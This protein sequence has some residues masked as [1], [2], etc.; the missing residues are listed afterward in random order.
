MKVSGG[1]TDDGVIVGNTFDKYSSKNPIVRWIM[2]GFH[3][4]LNELV[5]AAGPTSIHE[6][7]CGEGYWV[8]RW[9]RQGLDARGSDFSPT[10]V[11][12]ANE[13]AAEQD[14]PS[15]LFNVRSI[16]ELRPEVD[17]ADLVVCCEVLEHLEDPRAALEQ[18]QSIAH[19]HLILSVPREPLW[20]FMNMARGRYWGQ[21]G[22]TPGH[23]Q[24]WS[25]RGFI[26]LVAQ[27]FDIDR[28]LAPIPWTMLHCRS[29]HKA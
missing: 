13:N 14:L 20:S 25:Q 16:Y 15:D 5:D 18:L 9:K 24:Q 7:G 2:N 12:I 28:V 6:V 29:R 10:V 1:L 19:R 27:Y 17:S 4:S 26:R 22:N 3:A 11:A 21:L 8:S 23:I